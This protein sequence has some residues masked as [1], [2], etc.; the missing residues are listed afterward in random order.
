MIYVI[1]IT[2]AFV[3]FWLTKKALKAPVLP[4][5]GG[6]VGGDTTP[7]MEEVDVIPQP[8]IFVDEQMSAPQT[9]VIEPT[10]EPA[11]PK[12]RKVAP[13]KTASRVVPKKTAKKQ[14]KRK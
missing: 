11:K 2:L 12:P 3:A 14:Q 5:V 8:D 7:V 13:K 6:S 9:L 4:T 10:A 1:A